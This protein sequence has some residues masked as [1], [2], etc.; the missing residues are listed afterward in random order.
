MKKVRFSE[1]GQNVK[2][3]EMGVPFIVTYHPLLSK[4][5]LRK[6]SN[7]GYPMRV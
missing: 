6:F 3:V 7:A 4:P 1:Q 2:K 5:L